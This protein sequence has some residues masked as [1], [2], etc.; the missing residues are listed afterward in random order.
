MSSALAFYDGFRAERLPANL[1]QV[2]MS[3][4][5]FLY[6]FLSVSMSVSCHRR[7]LLAHTMFPVSLQMYS[8]YRIFLGWEIFSSLS[9]TNLNL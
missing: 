5:C 3:K 6:A 4:Y 1:I 7:Y 2:N 9:S 8:L